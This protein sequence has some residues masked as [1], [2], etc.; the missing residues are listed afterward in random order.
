MGENQV[1]RKSSVLQKGERIQVTLSEAAMKRLMEL[2]EDKCV[3]RSALI[4]MALDKFY[5]TE[6]G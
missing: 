2:C 6:K 1:S 4:A 3:K 5:K